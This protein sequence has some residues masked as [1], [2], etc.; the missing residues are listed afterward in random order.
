MK[1]YSQVL[2]QSDQNSRRQKIEAVFKPHQI[3]EDTG[4]PDKSQGVENTAP[5]VQPVSKQQRGNIL[6]LSNLVD[7]DKDDGDDMI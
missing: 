3:Y 1:P 5:E 6:D 2:D 7:D 4:L